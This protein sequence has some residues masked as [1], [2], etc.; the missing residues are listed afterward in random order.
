MCIREKLDRSQCENREISR[1]RT[2]KEGNLA[3]FNVF[4]R[5]KIKEKIRFYSKLTRRT[6]K[7]SIFQ[8]NKPYFG[9][10]I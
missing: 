9:R 10:K 1:K 8:Q 3:I 6:S 4:R 7:I 2:K 5:K